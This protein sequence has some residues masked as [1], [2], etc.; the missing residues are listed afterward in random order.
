MV[1]GIVG[2]MYFQMQIALFPFQKELCIFRGGKW[3]SEPAAAGLLL[4]V[5]STEGHHCQNQLPSKH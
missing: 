1:T 5:L 3:Q 2:A 4:G